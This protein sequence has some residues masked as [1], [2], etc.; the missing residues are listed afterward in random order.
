MREIGRVDDD[1][2]V[3]D[4]QRAGRAVA[5]GGVAL[6]DL[7][8]EALFVYS[9]AGGAQLIGAAA[10]AGL[11]GGVEEELDVRVGEDD[12]TLVAPLAH[13]ARMLIAQ[14][15]LGG[16]ENGADLRQA[17]DARRGE[18]DVGVA[19]AV[20]HVARTGA[21]EEQARGIGGPVEAHRPPFDGK[22]HGRAV[23]EVE[24]LLEG[25]EGGGAIHGA[26]VKKLEAQALR[27]QARRRG[28]AGAGRSVDR[29][30]EAL[31]GVHG[32][33]ASAF[34]RAAQRASGGFPDRLNPRPRGVDRG[35]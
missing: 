11:G 2:V 13:E 18:S 14:A 4:D 10:G 28:L 27:H 32:R 16:D 9:L 20:G 29:D 34:G 22:R 26:G 12:R 15:A 19:Q 7:A 25:D 21:R 8:E 30:G 1:G 35:N 3:G 31:S 17:R 33:S 24:A 23:G 6:D 5:V